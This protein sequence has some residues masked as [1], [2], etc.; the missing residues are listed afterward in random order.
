MCINHLFDWCM[1]AGLRIPGDQRQITSALPMHLSDLLTVGDG[2]HSFPDSSGDNSF[3]CKLK[4]VWI[5][6]WIAFESIHVSF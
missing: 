5:E 6:Y 1:H 3:L 2:G 4:Y